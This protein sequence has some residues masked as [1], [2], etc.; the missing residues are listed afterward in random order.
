MLLPEILMMAI[1]LALDA[2]AVCLGIGASGRSKSARARFRLAFHFGLF[3]FMMP[4]IGWFAGSTV[5][6]FVAAFGDWVAFAVLAF[7]GGRMIHAGLKHKAEVRVNDPSR[8]MTLVMLS[9]ATSMDALAVGFSLAMLRIFIWYPSI[10]I[11]LTTGTLSTCGLLLG[12]RLGNKFGDRME[13]VGGI[14]LMLI[15]FHIVF[16]RIM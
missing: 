16:P 3:Q 4:V 10:V 6:Q 7:V 15:G 11:G 1:G 14:I 8:G 2:T 12:D 9:L 5:Q 13:I